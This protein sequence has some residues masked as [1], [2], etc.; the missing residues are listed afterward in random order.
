MIF[1]IS[2]LRHDREAGIWNGRP[3]GVTVILSR[4]SFAHRM[5]VV[6]TL[7]PP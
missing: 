6:K 4:K 7:N 5:L 1:G 2:Q 3:F